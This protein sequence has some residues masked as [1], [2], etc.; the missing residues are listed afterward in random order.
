MKH[1]HDNTLQK[2]KDSDYQVVDGQPDIDGWRILNSEQEEIG[3]VHD[4]LFDPATRKVRYLI[5][6]L[7]QEIGTTNANLVLIPIGMAELHATDNEVSLPT[8]TAGQ[9]NQFSPYP[10]DALRNNATTGESVPASSAGL[11]YDHDQFDEKRFY[12]NRSWK[13]VDTGDQ[14]EGARIAQ[15]ISRDAGRSSL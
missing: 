15:R 4:L 6:H 14:S 5:A 13:A 11:N 3:S 2:L 1:P 9:L 10:Y 7:S 12:R 8:I